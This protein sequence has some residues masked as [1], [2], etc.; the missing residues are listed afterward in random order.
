M[1]IYATTLEGPLDEASTEE[2]KNA[3]SWWYFILE[4]G[5]NHVCSQDTLCIFQLY[6]SSF[7]H[8]WPS[9]NI[10]LS[11]ATE[12]T[13]T[14]TIEQERYSQKGYRFVGRDMGGGKR[15][16]KKPQIEFTRSYG[17]R[18]I[19]PKTSCKEK[20]HR[21]KKPVSPRNQFVRI[22]LSKNIF[23]HLKAISICEICFK[24]IL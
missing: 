13:L 6:E 7:F 2:S 21:K 14:N 17:W 8:A 11:L 3:E 23:S 18:V 15:A 4:P 1:A 16:G 10:H 9:L 5:P 24:I 20:V 12:R 19:W 22:L